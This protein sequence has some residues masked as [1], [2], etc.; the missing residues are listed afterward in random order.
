MAKITQ[1]SLSTVASPTSVLNMTGQQCC[2]GLDFNIPTRHL[3]FQPDLTP[4]SGHKILNMHLHIKNIKIFKQE[5][6]SACSQIQLS[7]SI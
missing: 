6:I 3:I 1:I 2:K 4:F 5:T 7:I